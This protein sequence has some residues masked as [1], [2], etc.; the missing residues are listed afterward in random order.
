MVDSGV[1][2]VFVTEPSSGVGRRMESVLARLQLGKR[3]LRIR[4]VDAVAEPELVR[5][6]EVDEIP[7]IV[8][9]KDSRPFARLPGRSTLGEIEQ[10]L[11][12]VAGD[13]G[14]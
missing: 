12:S 2:V 5:R 11:R 3:P 6:L 9:V 10:A 13:S 1:V 7:S 8:M 14:G 4:R